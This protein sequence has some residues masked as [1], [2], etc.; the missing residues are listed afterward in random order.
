MRHPSVKL[1]ACT[2][3]PI[4]VIFA[5]E[6]F[7]KSRSDNPFLIDSAYIAECRQAWRNP[8]TL[9]GDSEALFFACYELGILEDK[10]HYPAHKLQNLYEEELKKRVLGLVQMAVPVCESVC[11]TFQISDVSI[12]WREQL[13]RHRTASYWIQS[14]RITDYSNVFEDKAY[15][16]PVDIKADPEALEKWNHHWEKTQEFFRWM[17][18]AGIREQDAREIIGNGVLHRLS[19]NINLRNLAHMLKARTCFIAQQHWHPIVMA[20][21]AGMYEVDPMFEALAKPPCLSHDNKFSQCAY[22][23]MAQD[24][25]DGTDPLPVCPLFHGHLKDKR[26]LKS[27]DELAAEGKW[28][29][30]MNKQYGDFWKAKVD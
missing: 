18:Q 28:D 25:H 23:N 10:G 4:E 2:P 29:P 21:C 20:V 7:A 27:Q 14:G 12:A 5:T 17:R 24:R 16:V 9:F 1:E 26:K 19:W 13:V 11:F 30:A 22:D 3:N 8:G 6:M 15:H